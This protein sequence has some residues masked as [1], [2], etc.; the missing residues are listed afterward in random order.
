MAEAV[1]K[2]TRSTS[3]AKAEA[4]EGASEK[5]RSGSMTKEECLA[6]GLDPVPYGLSK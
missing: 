1:K 5:A 2:A 3:K 4:K 6:R